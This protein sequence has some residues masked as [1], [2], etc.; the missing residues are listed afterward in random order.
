M[1][2][3]ERIQALSYAYLLFLGV[4]CIIGSTFDQRAGVSL[5]LGALYIA[6]AARQLLKVRSTS[7]VLAHQRQL[8]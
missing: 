6:V 2:H 4:V 3:R 5:L 8:H 1:L 7:A